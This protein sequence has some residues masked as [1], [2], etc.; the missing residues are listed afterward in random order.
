MLKSAAVYGHS[1]YKKFWL[2]KMESE[3]E[4]PQSEGCLWRISRPLNDVNCSALELKGSDSK[5]RL[6]SVRSMEDKPSKVKITCEGSELDCALALGMQL[7][8][9]DPR[10]ESHK[11]KKVQRFVHIADDKKV[12]AEVLDGNVTRMCA[13][14]KTEKTPLWRNGP[15]GPKSL[16]NACGIRYKKIGKRCG[17]NSADQQ[18]P[19]AA[20]VAKSPV[21]PSVKQMTKI[22]KRKQ[23][24]D[25]LQNST[26]ANP[27][28][29]KSNASSGNRQTD[30]R[31]EE[32]FYLF[33]SAESH[34]ARSREFSNAAAGNVACPEMSCCGK[35]STA[36]MMMMRR[37]FAKDEEEGAVLL[38]ALSCGVVNA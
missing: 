31:L 9:T 34:S 16:C 37:S 6:P 11:P 22:S 8:R 33:N 4:R 24:T 19:S 5:S 7:P 17:G 20:A 14:C 35:M 10:D 25:L 27:S 3:D 23:D 1:H 21:S 12:D 2:K 18:K 32:S 38:M 29:K 13:D 26:V 30:R 28:R 15:H 36:A